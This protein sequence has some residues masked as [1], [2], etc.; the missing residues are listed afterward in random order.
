MS[1]CTGFRV[2][3]VPDDYPGQLKDFSEVEFKLPEC[4]ADAKITPWEMAG[5]HYKYA[6]LKS[7]ECPCGKCFKEGK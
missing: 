6:L 5:L 1:E 2:V 7:K 3:L 4:L